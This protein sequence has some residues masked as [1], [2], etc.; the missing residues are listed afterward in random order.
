MP[1]K[2]LREFLDR[3]YKEGQLLSVKDEVLPEP[4]LG[5]A[6]YAATKMPGGGAVIFEKIKGYKDKRVVMNVHG[7]WQNCALMFDLPKN[8]PVKQIFEEVE[9]RWDIFP[10]KPKIVKNAPVKDVIISD[11]INIFR[12]MAAF[13]VNEHDGGCYLSKAAVVTKDPEN[14]KNQNV[15]MYRLQVKDKDRLGIQA[16]AHH[17]IGIHL[18]KSEELNRPLPV[19]IA[20]G[21]DPMVTLV[22]ATGLEYNEDEYEMAG[23]LRGKPL[24][25]VKAE[26]SELL[27]PAWSEIVLEGEIIPRR[28]SIEG[29]FGEFTGFYSSPMLQAEIKIN[30]IT[31]RKDAVFENLY[32][33][34]PWS[35]SDF[36]LGLTTSVSVYKQLKKMAPEVVAVNAMYCHGMGVIISTRS[37]VGGYGKIVAAKLLATPHGLVYPKLIIVVDEDIDPFN[38]EKV[39]WALLTRFRAERDLLLVP[40]SPGSTLDPA[41]NPRGLVT[42]MI[43]DAT[44]PVA[45]DL[46]LQDLSLINPPKEA[47]EWLEKLNLLKGAGQ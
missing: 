25:I 45:P 43:L 42:R 3:L 9:R 28:R 46:V 33:G 13:R 17:D 37:R 19:A 7:S 27:V 12:E 5:A 29:P 26:T 21:N 24:E 31:R 30:T 2:D 23:A 32:I 35:E 15:G 14:P 16:G 10:V 1:Y 11:D 41:S 40:N 36:I 20:V 4:D 22:A 38:L 8:A 44:K 18:R 6:A 34:V 39:V 47:N